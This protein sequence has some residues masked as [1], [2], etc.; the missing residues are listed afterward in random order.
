MKLE[1]GEGSAGGEYR[2]AL[3]RVRECLGES[4]ACAWRRVRE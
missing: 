4:I 1:E 2:C 3:R